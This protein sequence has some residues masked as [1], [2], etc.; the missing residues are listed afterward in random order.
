SSG[1]LAR[2]NGTSWSIVGGDFVGTVLGLD[3]YNNELIIGGSYPGITGNPNIAKYNSTT[4]VYSTLGTGGTDGAVYTVLSENGN[5]YAGGSFAHAG[6]VAATNLARWNGSTWSSVRGGADGVVAALAG[7]HNEVHAGGGFVNVRNAAINSPG[8]ARYLE[9]GAPW[10]ARDPL[11]TSG[12]CNGEVSFT[13]SGAAGY[14]GLTYPWRHN[15][16]PLA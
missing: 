5:L 10:I 14:G 16:A 12:P 13:A 15:G 7:F 8:W 1:G 9:T 11:G 3:V 2:W 4:G 6:G